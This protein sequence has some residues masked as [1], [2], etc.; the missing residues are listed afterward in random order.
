MTKFFV[1]YWKEDVF[2]MNWKIKI[3]F[4]VYNPQWLPS[5]RKKRERERLGSSLFSVSLKK[6][7]IVKK[8]KN[9]NKMSC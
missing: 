6:V 2:L 4:T 5:A 7:K 9:K 3:V 1:C 8:K